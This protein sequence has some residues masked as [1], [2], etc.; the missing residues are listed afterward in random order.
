MVRKNEGIRDLV[1]LNALLYA[2]FTVL[3]LLLLLQTIPA[4]NYTTAYAQEEEDYSFITKWG[5]EGS[6]P[7]EFMGQNDAVPSPDGKYIYVP[8]YENHRIQK[9]TSNGTYIMEW[10]SGSENSANGEFDNPHSIDIDSHG[11]VYV[12]DKDNHRIQKFTN[13]GQF[14]TKW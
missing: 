7:G 12:S 6:A 4:P 1:N 2:I 14:I 11:N 3:A 13:D 5:L 8:D 9:F 10:G